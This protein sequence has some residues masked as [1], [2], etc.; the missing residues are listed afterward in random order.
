MPGASAA[1]YLEALPYDFYP[2]VDICPTE[3]QLRET[4]P[5]MPVIERV[6]TE[7][8]TEALD[9]AVTVYD[10]GDSE[11]DSL[12]EVSSGVECFFWIDEAEVEFF[13]IGF[14]VYPFQEGAE[15]W[16][17]EAAKEKEYTA[18]GWDQ[19]SYVLVRDPEDLYA[20]D[21]VDEVGFAGISGQV[22]V[23]GGGTIA[24]GDMT[25]DAT[26]AALFALATVNADSLWER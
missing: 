11:I 19:A 23:Y 13:Q 6:E 14:G 25:K 10:N 18:P 4:F 12:R 17:A 20:E 5:D 26:V 7:A 24:N 9:T 16:Y 22:A 3:A 2:E 15:G 1:E 21:A 8:F